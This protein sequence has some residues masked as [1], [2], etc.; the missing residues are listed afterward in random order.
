M[1]SILS[2]LINKGKAI[3]AD[4]SQFSQVQFRVVDIL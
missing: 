4:E 3:V 2:E 1:K